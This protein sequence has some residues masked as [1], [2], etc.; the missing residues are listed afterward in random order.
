MPVDNSTALGSKR[1]AQVHAVLAKEG[2]AVPM[3]DLF[4]VVGRALRPRLPG[5]PA[6]GGVPRVVIAVYGAV[7]SWWG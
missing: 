3:T 7:W 6:P 1:K 4:G 5:L 2:L